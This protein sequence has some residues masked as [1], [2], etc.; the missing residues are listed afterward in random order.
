MV[1]FFSDHEASL[2]RDAYQA[3]GLLFI[4]HHEGVGEF[5]SI[6]GEDLGNA[7]D[8]GEQDV[9]LMAFDRLLNL[10]LIDHREGSCYALSPQGLAHASELEGEPAVIEIAV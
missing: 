6:G 8:L 9:V 4:R 3:Q 2:L 5:L 7:F 10:G 1:P